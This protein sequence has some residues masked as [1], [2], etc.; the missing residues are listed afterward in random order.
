[1][2]TTIKRDTP[3]LTIG[4]IFQTLLENTNR[5]ES[6]TTYTEVA[7]ETR[8]KKYYKDNTKCLQRTFIKLRDS[9]R[10]EYIL[11]LSRE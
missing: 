11:F 5:K 10:P 3:N 4:G 8:T 9:I 6:I 1:M 2:E 7:T